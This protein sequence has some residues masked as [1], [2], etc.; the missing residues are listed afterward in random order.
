MDYGVV[1]AEGNPAEIQNN[2]EVIKAYLGGEDFRDRLVEIL[3]KV[4]KGKQGETYKGQEMRAHDEAQAEQIFGKGLRTLNLN[5]QDLHNMDKG[6][7]EKQV[8]A[9][10]LRK[11][12]V[13]SRV[14]ISQRLRMGDVSRV[15]QA[16]SAVGANK[17]IELI[18]LK[19]RLG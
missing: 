9:W 19:K 4:V 3:G 5:E 15:T 6:A 18:K 11:K 2:P 12:T 10:W 16:V 1:I 8:L 17:D 14:W 7:R 13:I